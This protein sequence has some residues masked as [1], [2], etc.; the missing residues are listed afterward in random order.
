MGKI[1]RYV[2]DRRNFRIGFQLLLTVMFVVPLLILLNCAPSSSIQVGFKDPGFYKVKKIAIIPFTDAPG[3]FG[4]PVK[5]SGTLVGDVLVSEISRLGK[6]T[7]VERSQV[8]KV[9]REQGFQM[10]GAVDAS[11]AKE[12]GKI[13][14]VDAVLLGSL[15]EY[16]IVKVTPWYGWIALPAAVIG[17]GWIVYTL[18][19]HDV[20]IVGMTIR[21]V[22]VKTGRVMFTSD[23]KGTGSSY[24]D[25]AR[26]CAK[27]ISNRL[28]GR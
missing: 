8:N 10:S 4:Q 15:S 2:E 20:A 1:L 24:M 19:Q 22:D 5:N 14:G 23:G 6:Y 27:M 18:S 16:R 26:Q 25:A 21:V 3:K 28:I 12:V 13:L 11:T 9:L 7:I 17:I